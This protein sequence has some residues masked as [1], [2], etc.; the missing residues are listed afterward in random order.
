M[1]G[2]EVGTILILFSNKTWV[3]LSG[4]V[5]CQINGFWA[6]YNPML[7][8]EVPLHDVKVVVWWAASVTLIID[9]LPL[10]LH[11]IIP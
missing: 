8:H 10:S 11:P 3:Q 6:A 5:S 7:I 9:T 2:S 4:H 1:H